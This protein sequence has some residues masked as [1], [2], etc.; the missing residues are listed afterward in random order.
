[1]AQ[2]ILDSPGA[3]RSLSPYCGMRAAATGMSQLRVK[4]VGPAV[5]ACRLHPRLRTYR[6]KATNRRFG[7]IAD[8]AVAVG[9]L[10]GQYSL[11]F[12]IKRDLRPPAGDASRQQFRIELV[13]E[14]VVIQRPSAGCSAHTLNVR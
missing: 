9:D 14:T 6:C 13:T 12:R 11:A 10:T 3:W 8:I 4:R 5:S 2:P 7:P 1:M